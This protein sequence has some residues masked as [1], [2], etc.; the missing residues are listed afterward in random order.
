MTVCSDHRPLHLCLTSFV[1]NTLASTKSI[2]PKRELTHCDW[3]K[4]T[5]TMV[6]VYQSLLS[7]SLANI[8]IPVCLV[9]C[10]GHCNN[11]QHDSAIQK[12]YLD[13]MNCVKTASE[14]AIPLH[15]YNRIAIQ[16]TMFQGGQITLV[17]NMQL[18]ET[19]F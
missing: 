13:I 4:V 18:P 15:R 8:N 17:I 3:S 10:H 7:E 2:T 5:P 14:A 9:T 11:V 1:S 6:D 19:V 12:Y 16:T